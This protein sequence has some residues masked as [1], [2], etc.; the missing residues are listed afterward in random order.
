MRQTRVSVFV[1]GHAI[2]WLCGCARYPD[3]DLRPAQPLRPVV[4]GDETSMQRSGGIAV[5]PLSE[6]DYS[7]TATV[8]AKTFV[9]LRWWGLKVARLK[10]SQHDLVLTGRS[11]ELAGPGAGAGEVVTER[12]TRAL[13]QRDAGPAGAAEVRKWCDSNGV[14]P[15]QVR[16]R[17]DLRVALA[18]DVGAQYVVAGDVDLCR[19]WLLLKVPRT[20]GYSWYSVPEIGISLW[21][22]D[23]RT[24][25]TLRSVHHR[26]S[27]EQLISRPLRVR[28]ADLA[29][30]K[31]ISGVPM[32]SNFSAAQSIT[33]GWA[34]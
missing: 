4:I 27:G 12:V 6:P 17:P 25:E 2:I 19:S 9:D 28:G 26:L 24:G 1:L 23:G 21:L 20:G 30:N 34:C 16:M 13:A 11:R 32:F 31:P 8:N 18:A 29:K 7:N 33:G 15:A 14:S 22:Y 5:L 3:L 10:E